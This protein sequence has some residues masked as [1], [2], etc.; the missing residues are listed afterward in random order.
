VF[1]LYW[2][3]VVPSFVL[4]LL[5]GLYRNMEQLSFPA[6]EDE[7]RWQ[8]QDL[9]MELHNNHDKKHRDQW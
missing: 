9:C 3:P 4:S 8:P 1:V 7:F 2:Q 6:F 5:Q